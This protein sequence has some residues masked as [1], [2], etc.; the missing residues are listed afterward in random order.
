MLAAI[1]ALAGRF[2]VLETELRA[3][4]DRLGERPRLLRP[5]QNDITFRHL[6]D[7]SE[8]RRPDFPAQASAPR[9]QR[10]QKARAPKPIR[11]RPEP[12]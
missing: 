1:A 9:P 5:R 6:A 2:P 8:R 7:A 4:Q 11:S 12:L 10:P 3:A